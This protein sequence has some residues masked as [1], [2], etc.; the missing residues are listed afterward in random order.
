[1]WVPCFVR[2]VIA[3]GLGG[4]THAI[5]IPG[6]IGGLIAMN[7][8]SQRHGI[9]ENLI[10]V[11]VLDRQGRAQRVAHADLNFGYRTSSIHESGMTIVSARFRFAETGRDA[12]RHEAIEILRQRRAKFPKVR[13]NCGSVFVSDPALYNLIGPAGKA[14]DAVGLKGVRRG[15]AEISAEHA[16]FIVNNGGATSRDVIDLIQLAQRGVRDATG[17]SMA[18]EVRYLQPRGSLIAADQ[19]PGG[20]GK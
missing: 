8:G 3:L 9:G 1:M 14:I 2:R 4:V 5:G 7:G 20:D 13:A 16:N 10:D 11:D 15:G 18:T 19:A 12:L 6:T 17:I